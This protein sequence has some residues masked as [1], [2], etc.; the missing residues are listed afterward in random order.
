MGLWVP[1]CALICFGCSSRSPGDR[2]DAGTVD[3]GLVTG[4]YDGGFFSSEWPTFPPCNQSRLALPGTIPSRISHW[5]SLVTYSRTESFSSLPLESDVY[6]YDLDTC[7]EY[8]LTRKDGDQST[9]FIHGTQIMFHDYPDGTYSVLGPLHS[10]L[11]LFD[12]A[13]HEFTYVTQGAHAFYPIHNTRFVA[14]F[15]A[16]PGAYDLI[17]MDLVL[18]NLSS[19]DATT[20]HNTTMVSVSIVSMSDTHIAWSEI[21]SSLEIGDLAYSDLATGDVTRISIEPGAEASGPTVWGDWLLWSEAHDGVQNVYARNIQT[22]LDQQLT[23]DGYNHQRPWLH[24]A[25]ACWL[26]DR[27]SGGDEWDLLLYDVE[28]G[29]E[30]RLTT[31]SRPYW[32]PGFVHGGW[33]VYTDGVVEPYPYY[34]VEAHA[35]DLLDLGF[36]DEDGHLIPE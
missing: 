28:T 8:Q 10:E 15:A 25:I 1:L 7:T 35:V 4:E 36:I 26:T 31:E 21:S 27:Y 29:V 2:R 13:T 6:L 17:N 23:T 11:V 30:R 9:P 34:G 19:G 18:E 3:S 12:T 5:N 20:L 24:G 22:G 14:Y 33:I 32:H 16:Y